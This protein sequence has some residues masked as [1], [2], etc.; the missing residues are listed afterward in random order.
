[1]VTLGSTLP[2]FDPLR[3]QSSYN[4]FPLRGCTEILIHPMVPRGRMNRM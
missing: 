1:M 4:I 3:L 2:D